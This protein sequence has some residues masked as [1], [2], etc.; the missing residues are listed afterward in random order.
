[1]DRGGDKEVVDIRV[2]IRNTLVLLNHKIKRANIEVVEDFDESLP[3]INAM[4][5]ELNQVWTNLIDNASD[6]LESQKGAK[7][8]IRTRLDH[9]FA[10]VSI[11]DNGPGIPKDIKSKIFDPFF[12]TKEIG[13]GTGLGLDVVTRIVKQHRGSVTVTSDP[14]HTEFLVCFPI[15]G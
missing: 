3:P 11:I 10:K 12:T 15:N 8:I 4:V 6:A 9:E 13:K 1:M 7:L 2:G 5:G 14:G